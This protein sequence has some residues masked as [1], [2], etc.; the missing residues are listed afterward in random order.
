MGE[1]VNFVNDCRHSRAIYREQQPP[2]PQLAPRWF[3]GILAM[4]MA[5]GQNPVRPA[6]IKPTPTKALTP[7]YPG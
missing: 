7:K 1:R 4:R 5:I 2:P 6:T 3:H